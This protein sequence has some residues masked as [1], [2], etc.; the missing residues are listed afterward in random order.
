MVC[1]STSLNS[2]TTTRKKHC[3]ENI[4]KQL[5]ILKNFEK[6]VYPNKQLDDYS[7]IDLRIEE[8]I[9]VKE[10]YRKG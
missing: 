3:G 1:H 10:K 4:F 7:Y 5:N 2:G 6:T 9:V 8:Q